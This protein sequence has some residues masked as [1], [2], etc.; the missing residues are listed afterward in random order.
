MD[1]PPGSVAAASPFAGAAAQLEALA[2]GT[3]TSAELTEAA[4]ARIARLDPELNAFRVVLAGT[5]RAQAAEADARRAAGERAPLLGVPVAIKDDT[6]QAGQVTTFGTGGPDQASTVDSEVVRRLRSAGAVI[7]GRTN[8]PELLLLPVT[9]SLT[10]GATRNPWDLGRTPGGSSGGSAAAVAAGIVPVALGSDG[11]GSVRIPAACCG[12]FGLKTTRDLI[13]VAPHSARDH[14]Y[15]GLAVYGPLSRNVLDAALF[16]DA[17]A[18][19]PAAGGFADAARTTPPPLRI[20]LALRPPIPVP[21]N[22]EVIR[23]TRATAELLREL[24]HA[25]V[26]V[27]PRYAPGVPNFLIRFISGAA[28]SAAALPHNERFEQRTRRIAAIGR[29]IPRTLVERACTREQHVTQT[30]HAVFQEID[31]L[32]TPTLAAPPLPTGR[33]H[34]RGALWTLTAAAAWIPFTPPWNTTG[35]PAAN[36]PAGTSTRGLPLGVQLAAPPGADR[37]LLSLSAQLEAA[38]PW[39]QQHPPTS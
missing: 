6:E 1:F 38:R 3:V 32:L 5:A 12:L 11:G 26:E 4:L 9:E 7:V 14:T 21:I 16:L 34:G 36:V 29:A 31:V 35:A 27:R 33:W 18:D 20:G 23:A 28:I 30:L 22:R 2:A 19:P 13:P 25:I 39:A 10:W 8:A 24:G 17:V 37:L 15:H